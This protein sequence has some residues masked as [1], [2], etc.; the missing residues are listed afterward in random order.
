M[1]P[2]SERQAVPL[3]RERLVELFGLAPSEA[4][5]DPHSSVPRADAVIGLGE[6]L[7]VVE[8]KGSGDVATVSN[9]VR[10]VRSYAAA[11]GEKAIPLVAVPFMGS[12]GRDYCREADVGWFDLSGNAQILA[13]GLRVRIE[14]QPNRFKHPGRPSSAFAPKSARIARWLL[15]HSDR[16]ATQR[17]IARATDMDEGFTSRIV[18]KLEEDDLIVRE[19]EGTIRV[20]DPDL[21]L[22]A[23]RE[24]YD[25]TKHHILRGHVPARSGHA[26]LRQMVDELG[27]RDT[28][29]AATGLAG[30]WL[31]DR[32]AG[33]RL[34][35]LYLAEA[36]DSE[37]LERLGFREDKRGANTWLVVPNDEGVFHGAS[38]R[39]GACCVH[40]VQVYLDLKAHPERADEAGEELRAALS[41]GWSAHA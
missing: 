23:W 32:F 15:I 13:P 34:V 1:Q 11:L 16:S 7:F 4:R 36:P 30:A 22:D 25:F 39:D 27:Q 10:Q 8:Y 9:A 20:R 26:L 14:G 29:Y 12:V 3:L 24:D 6:F 37:L 19:P 17:E 18:A 21:L 31:I 38:D 35:T 33:F 40:P 41:E 5:I 28:R 2:P